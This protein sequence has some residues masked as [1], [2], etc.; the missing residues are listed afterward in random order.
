VI[1]VFSAL[2]VGVGV[3]TEVVDGM[4]AGDVLMGQGVYMDFLEKIAVLGKE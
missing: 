4:V 2:L 3:E 1:T